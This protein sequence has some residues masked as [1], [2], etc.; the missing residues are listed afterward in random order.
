MGAKKYE[1]INQLKHRAPLHNILQICV[2]PYPSVV[3]GRMEKRQIARLF[4]A[5]EVLW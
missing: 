5:E 1:K 3:R 2:Q 4:S